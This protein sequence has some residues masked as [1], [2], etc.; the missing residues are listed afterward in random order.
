MAYNKNSDT[1]QDF[2]WLKGMYEDQVQ[3]GRSLC[4]AILV[5]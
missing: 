3:Q 4:P 1:L 5:L 2:L